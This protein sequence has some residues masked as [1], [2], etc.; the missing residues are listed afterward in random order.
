[1]YWAVVALSTLVFLLGAAV[2]VF[3]IRDTRHRGREEILRHV[4]NET[5]EVRALCLELHHTKQELEAAKMAKEAKRGEEIPFAFPPK[6]PHNLVPEERK[7]INSFSNPNY[8]PELNPFEVRELV[9]KQQQQQ[10]QEVVA[11][12]NQ[13]QQQ[14]RPEVAVAASKALAKPA[15]PKPEIVVVAAEVH[16]E[17]EKQ[18]QQRPLDEAEAMPKFSLAFSGIRTKLENLF[19]PRPVQQPQL[20]PEV[21]AVV[22]TPKKQP[23]QVVV[24]AAPPQHQPEAVTGTH[25]AQPQQGE[26]VYASLVF[27]TPQ[28]GK[29]EPVAAAPIQKP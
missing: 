10:L 2:V 27:K 26:V 8:R 11:V 19:E 13:Q 18:Q 23:E 12:P 3:L 28:G 1:M 29:Q 14:Q 25:A 4:Q 22:A 5:Q 9:S 6:T 7:V 15:Q 20:Q 21:V 17:P 16:A 24:E